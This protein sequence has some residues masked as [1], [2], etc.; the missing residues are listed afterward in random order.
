M[1]KKTVF[2]TLVVLSFL[3][4]IVAQD[5]KFLVPHIKFGGEY[6]FQSDLSDTSGNYSLASGMF[7]FTYPI[8]SS[9]F[10]LTNDL[11]YK[12][13]VLIA[14]INGT[15]RLPHFSFIDAQHQLIAG[16]AGSSVIFNTGNKNTWIG[17]FTVGMAEDLITIQSFQ[18]RFSGLAALKHKLNG[19]FSYL[20]GVYY[21]FIYGRGLPLPILGAVIR[22]GDKSKLKII[23][24]LNVS[25]KLKLNPYDMLTVF[26]QP[27]GF[28]H[29]FATLNDSLFILRNNIVRFRQ[30]SFKI[31]A[32]VKIGL[33]EHIHITPEIGYLARRKI[34]FSE[35][36]LTAK[37]N[38]F[39]QNVDGTP[40]A[41]VMVRIL[42]GKLKWKRTGDNFLLNDDRL[43]DYDLDDPTN[44]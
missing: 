33:S 14:N 40:Y 26:I 12:S 31:G 38:F 10:A 37:E 20:A 2:S 36:G 32:S 8:I 43:D 11:S 7:G 42:I 27:D 24:P 1:I 13:I 41:K 44:L 34:A 17:N 29:N 21:S 4:D 6:A 16:N 5:K 22:T 39:S 30:Q 25:W 3:N 23:L 9:R 19:D 18:L 15:Y 28:Q 35:A